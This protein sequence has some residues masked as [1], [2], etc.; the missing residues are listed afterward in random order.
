LF[1]QGEKMEFKDFVDT[2][3]KDQLIAIGTLGQWM[4]EKMPVYCTCP[5]KCNQRCQLVKEL[6]EAMM[7]A[8][9]RLQA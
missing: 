7:L 6:N 9:K 4:Q 2:A 5:S 3:N 8:G 1:V